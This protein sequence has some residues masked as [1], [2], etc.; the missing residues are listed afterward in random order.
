MTCRASVLAITTSEA[1][2]ETIDRVLI[3][4]LGH[5]DPAFVDPANGKY[6]LSAGSLVAINGGDAAFATVGPWDARHGRRV[7]GPAPD[8]GA[9]E[10]GSLFAWDAEEGD[11]VAW[12]GQVPIAP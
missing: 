5:P 12:S 3:G 4:E 9:F 1:G 2:R 7:V 11:T 6:E 10:R 8:L